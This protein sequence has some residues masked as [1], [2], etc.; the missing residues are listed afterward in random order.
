MFRI[1]YKNTIDVRTR[2]RV[3]AP[4]RNE[5]IKKST[6][7]DSHAENVFHLFLAARSMVCLS[8]VRLILQ[9]TNL[10]E[11]T[12]IFSRPKTRKKHWKLPKPVTE[13]N[14]QTVS[15][16]LFSRSDSEIDD[17][18]RFECVLR[19]PCYSAN[20]MR[21]Q[22]VSYI[23][24]ERRETMCTNAHPPQHSTVVCIPSNG[25]SNEETI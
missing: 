11:N 19:A 10:D 6:K 16:G 1:H 12:W 7:I 18:M 4:K 15:I 13:R 5:N 24:Y 17:E 3:T 22:S 14:F 2:C 23:Y 9:S 21:E 20:W 25:I 8:G